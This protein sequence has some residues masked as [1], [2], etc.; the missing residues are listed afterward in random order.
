M[1][2]AVAAITVAGKGGAKGTAKPLKIKDVVD[3]D[4]AEKKPKGAPKPAA[5]TMHALNMK[6]P[7]LDAIDFSNQLC[8][9]LGRGTACVTKLTAMGMGSDCP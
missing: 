8:V 4:S 3:P 1:L 9:Q 7:I 6:D 2:P 5:A